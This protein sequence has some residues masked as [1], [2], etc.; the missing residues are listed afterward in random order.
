M[1]AGWKYNN[2]SVPEKVEAVVVISLVA[3][4]K[5]EAELAHREAGN[6]CLIDKNKP[7]HVK[8]VICQQR[9]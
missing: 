2:G 9:L 6:C 4:L 7:L 1:G 8:G 5:P 3:T